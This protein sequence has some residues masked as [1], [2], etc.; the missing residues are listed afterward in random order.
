MGS[1]KLHPNDCGSVLNLHDQAVFVTRDVEHHPVVATNACAAVLRLDV[2]RGQP[3]CLDRLV[4]PAL[5][6]TFGVGALR[7]IL[8]SD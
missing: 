1:H 8:K 4:E 6:G 5:Q 2:L 3:A 7:P